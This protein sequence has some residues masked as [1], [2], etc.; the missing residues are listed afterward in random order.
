MNIYKAYKFR[1]YP[2]NEQKI[3]IEKTFGCTRYIYNKLLEER[4]K[5]FEEKKILI[6]GS[7]QLKKLTEIKNKNEWLK[8]V[9][10][11]SL[12]KSVFKIDDAFQNF[13]RGN[14][15][16]KY[17]IKGV[18]ESY[19]TIQLHN[20]YKNS[21]YDSIKIDWKN[22]TITLPKLE[23]VSFSGYNNIKKTP[24]KIKSATI[25]KVANKYYV[26]FLIEVP[27]VAVKVHPKSV[28]GLDLGIKDFIVTSYG[29]KI[30]NE[31]K[32]NQKR[33]KGLQKG[34]SRC[35]T[36]SKNRYKI[37]MKIQ[38]LYQKIKNARKYFIHL[39]VNKILKENDIISTESLDIKNMYKNH[40]IA[41][42]LNQ[43]SM[44]EFLRTLKYKAQWLG[45]Y[46]IEIDKFYPSSQICSRCNYKSTLLKNLNIREWICP[47]CGCNHD[48]DI[49]ASENIMFEGLCLYMKKRYN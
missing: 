46:V 45:K 20:D 23:N 4:I 24:G 10:Q 40:S 29:E 43:I 1:I 39:T 2:T 41:K 8:E 30:K 38:T 47:K 49:N 18:H 28:V 35:K 42:C 13:I 27:F 14:G 17:K 22:R 21:K 31:I 7:S 11:S 9:D 34:L 19:T 33:L 44:G 25:S 3:L 12:F 48:R 6:K 32:I 26:S 5:I 37:K 16:P 15:Y 36:K